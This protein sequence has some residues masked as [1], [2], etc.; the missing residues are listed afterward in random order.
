MR[1][2]MQKK[3][4]IEMQLH[5]VGKDEI[6]EMRGYARPPDTVRRVWA[7]TLLLLDKVAIK[8]VDTATWSD[9]RRYI[10]LG[11]THAAAGNIFAQLKAFDAT[12][13]SSISSKFTKAEELIKG[14]SS[15]AVAATSQ[16]T[17][18]MFAWL[19]VVLH[20]HRIT[21]AKN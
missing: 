14:L 2:V 19:Q 7:I 15:D 3:R 16:P 8:D 10:H 6:R 11:E 21:H 20:L 17:S 9:I 12:R 1:L 13:S 18:L 4:W 5:E